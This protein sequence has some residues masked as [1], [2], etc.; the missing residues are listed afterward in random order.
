MFYHAV[1]GGR[2]GQ[3]SFLGPC[4]SS[5]DLSPLRC[6]LNP[7]DTLGAYFKQTERW[8]LIFTSSLDL[9]ED[10]ALVERGF[11]GGGRF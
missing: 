1:D 6:Q 9:G 4:L 11:E 2:G 3:F 5:Q 8:V 10:N 7:H